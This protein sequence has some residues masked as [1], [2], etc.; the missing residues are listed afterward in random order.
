VNRVDRSGLE[1]HPA[2]PARM[3]KDE[4]QW[5][6][7]N[8]IA[9]FQGNQADKEY[10]ADI[11]GTKYLI[12]SDYHIRGVEGF[13]LTLDY[14]EKN[15]SKDEKEKNKVKEITSTHPPTEKRIEKVHQYADEIEAFREKLPEFYQKTISRKLNKKQYRSE[16]ENVKL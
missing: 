7:D 1:D 5:Y 9:Q 4:E 14:I 2:C 6:F 13:L 15:F 11:Y 12:Q 10:I 8:V 16:R 3:S